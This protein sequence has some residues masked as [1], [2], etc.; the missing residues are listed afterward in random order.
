MNSLKGACVIAQSGGPTSVINASVYGAAITA[1]ENK[2]ENK[3]ITNVYG[4][5]YGIKGILNDNL[6]DLAQ[7]DPDELSL[8]KYTPSA[9]LGSCRYKLSDSVENSSDYEK[10][11]QIFKKYNIRYFF[12]IG[13]NDSMDTCNKISKFFLKSSYECNVIGIPKT[14]DNDIFATDHC[15][16]Y[17]SAAKYIATSLMEIYRDTIAYDTGSVTI[18]EI[19]GRNAGW[20]TAAASLAS[21]DN[22]GPDLIYLPEIAFDTDKFIDS[23]AQI[24]AKNKK[25][26]VAVSEG[27]RDKSGE[28]ISQKTRNSA[29]NST[30]SF[31]HAQLGGLASYLANLVSKELNIKVR[32]IELSLL[33]RCAAHCASSIDIEESY[34][35]G[36]EA[37]NAAVSGESDKMV[38]FEREKAK[39]DNYSC[40]TK[41]VNLSSVANVEKTVPLDWINSSQNGLKQEFV[42]Y[43]K[44]LL[45]GETKL[46]Y[47]D[48]LPRF[49]N[50]KMIRVK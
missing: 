11:L 40:K 33:Q 21:Y 12:Y 16:G 31:G 29:N 1:I 42:D 35:A 48:G 36:I 49:A 9:I 39:E 3:N 20:L 7:E 43:L 22:S 23:V 17:A 34:R 14:I 30:D 27:I 26:L 44:P 24:Y 18:V 2:K 50:L 38:A 37:V 4:A 10:I 19:M 15:P 25:C 28:L 6:I 47:E 45:K 13:G 46:P 8:L 5:L 41:L 32:G